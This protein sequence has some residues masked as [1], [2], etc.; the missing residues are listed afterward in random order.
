APAR[1][2][3]VASACLHPRTQQFFVRFKAQ[4]REDYA[5]PAGNANGL[6][7]RGKD[8]RYASPAVSGTGRRSELWMS[9]PSVGRLID[10]PG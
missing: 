4:T 9:L 3:T 2:S 1:S 7:M 10:E 5:D 8:I 6:N